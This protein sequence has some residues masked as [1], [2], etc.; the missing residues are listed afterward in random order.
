MTETLENPV[1]KDDIGDQLRSAT[2]AADN[3]QSFELPSAEQTEPRAPVETEKAS[4]VSSPDT[5]PETT[6][7]PERPRDA[8]GRFT[9]REDG[10]EIPESER[11]PAEPAQPEKKEPTKP[12]TPYVKAQKDQERLNRNR[13]EFEAEK[14]RERAEIAAEK[15]RIAQE[16]QQWEQQ[17]Q[18]PQQRNGQTPEHTSK[19]YADYAEQCTRKAQ[20]LREQGDIEGALEQ[21]DLAA[22]AALA[23]GKAREYETTVQYEQSAKQYEAAWSQDMNE[24]IRLEPDLSNKD[25]DLTKTVMGL[26][27]EYPGVFERIPPMR[28]P[29]GQTMGGFSFAAEVAK[30]RLKAGLASGLEEQL[31]TVTKERDELRQKTQIEG[32]GPSGPTSMKTFDQMTPAEQ[33]AW[34]RQASE[35]V[36][37]EFR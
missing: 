25:S 22:K 36:P 29:N 18:Q 20:A 32:A 37:I 9:T 15:Q 17:R 16:R 33:E 14:A 4:E 27:G 30:L 26:M 23:A 12:E 13:Q 6:E 19:E 24:R 21:T 7:K 3:G 34:L 1:I 35:N 10:T 31:K 2:E 28:L 5:K 11:K 8:L